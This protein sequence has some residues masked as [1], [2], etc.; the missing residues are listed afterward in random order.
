ML[1][2]NPLDAPRTYENGALSE[3]SARRR[4]ALQEMEQYFARLLLREMRASIPEDGIFPRSA[5]R[6][7]F[8]DMLDDALSAEM[9]R[10]GQLGLAKM[11]EEQL[12]IGEMQNQLKRET[13]GDFINDPSSAE[14]K[15]I[16][17]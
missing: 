11:L 10:S 9:A 8:E 13:S 6:R 17:K 1:Y 3:D 15:A 14:S 12:R 2:V 4:I 5:Q 16:V 7:H